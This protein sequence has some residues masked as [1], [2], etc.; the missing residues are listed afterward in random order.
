MYGSGICGI[1]SKMDLSSSGNT[2]PTIVFVMRRATRRL[3][4][5]SLW[6]DPEICD[7]R[8]EESSSRGLPCPLLRLR[9]SGAGR[10]G[11][12]DCQRLICQ[13]LVAGRAGCRT[14]SVPRACLRHQG[15]LRV[16]RQSALSA[17]APRKCPFRKRRPAFFVEIWQSARI[18]L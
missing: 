1:G 11:R 12:H 16:E 6:P 13:E 9:R 8:T 14:V 10:G 7:H 2:D 5:R 15:V 18:P 17:P 4:T 3:Q